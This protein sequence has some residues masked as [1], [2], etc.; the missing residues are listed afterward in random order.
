MIII[1]PSYAGANGVNG[2]VSP[3]ELDH[4]DKM[5]MVSQARSLTWGSNGQFKF[6]TCKVEVPV[7]YSVYPKVST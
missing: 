6:S 1:I 5:N 3:V 2:N 7:S 4:H